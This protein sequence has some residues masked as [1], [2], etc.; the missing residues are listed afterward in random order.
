MMEGVCVCVCAHVCVC[1]C[2]RMCVCVCVCVEVC[3]CGGL[4]VLK[5]RVIESLMDAVGEHAAE[6]AWVD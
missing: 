2:V 3:V 1:V 5:Q 4:C 6:D